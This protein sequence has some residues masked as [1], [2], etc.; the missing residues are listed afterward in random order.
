VTDPRSRVTSYANNW[1]DLPTTVTSPDAGVTAKTYDA[2]GNV[3]TSRDAR[4]QTTTYLYDDLN[5][6]AKATHADGSV[7]TFVYDQGANGKGRLTSM[8]DATGSM[9]WTYDGFGC[10]AEEAGSN[11]REWYER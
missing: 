2:A 7:I 10:A 8:S 1:L 3:L 5:R 6:R 11:G 9:S 4:G